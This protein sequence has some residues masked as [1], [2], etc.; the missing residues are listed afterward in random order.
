MN[1][2]PQIFQ[3]IR[4]DLAAA[5]ER[6]EKACAGLPDPPIRVEIRPDGTGFLL[7]AE[8]RIGKERPITAFAA[9]AMVML[10]PQ[11]APPHNPAGFCEFLHQGMRY[12]AAGPLTETPVEL[13]NS[14]DFCAAPVR[15]FPPASAVVSRFETLEPPPPDRAAIWVGDAAG[16]D[17]YEG[18]P[19]T[20]ESVP[21]LAQLTVAYLG[22]TIARANVRVGVAPG[23]PTVLIS[24]RDIEEGE[25]LMTSRTP[26][27]WLKEEYTEKVLE[28]LLTPSG[29]AILAK[30]G[31][32]PLDREAL[33]GL[34]RG[35]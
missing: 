20:P 13:E 10:Q 28:H 23:R 32:P 4:A 25:E 3:Q 17:P 9:D 2:A 26:Y 21:T 12:L 27:H 24:L 15:G 35:A 16:G 29:Q 19:R 18:V 22:K 30:E 1:R 6:Y 31:R 33:R 11:N 8:A 5:R 7:R 14:A 34:L